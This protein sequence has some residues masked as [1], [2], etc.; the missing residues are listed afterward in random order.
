VSQ[1][2]TPD[3]ARAHPTRTLWILALGAMAYA[4]AQ[5]MIV[6]ALPEIQDATGSS[7]ETVTWMLTAFLL[8]SSVAIPLLGRLGDIIG[9]E[10]VLLVS[11]VTFGAGSLICAVG[12]SSIAVMIGGRLVQGIGGA[13]FPLCF[14]II[15]DEFPPERVAASIGAIS[16]TFGVG[17]GLGLVLAGVFVDHLSVAW[18]FWFSLAVTA[19]SVWA[20]WRYVP[21]SPVRV[22]ARI[23]WAGGALLSVA[24]AAALLGVSQGNA[25]GWGSAGVLGLL[26]AGAAVLAL[27]VAY[28]LRVSEPMVDMRLMAARAVWSPNVAAFAV[29][30]AMFGSYILIPELVQTD[31]SNGYGFGLS[32][33]TAGLVMLPSALVMLRSGVLAGR[34]SDRYGSRLPL[35]LGSAFAAL[36][37]GMLAFAHGSAWLVAI[38]GVPLGIGIGMAMAAMATLVVSVVPQEVTGIAMGVNTLMRNVGGAVGG[39]LAATLLAAHSLQNDVPAESGYTNAFALSLV[40]SIVALGACALVPKPAVADWRR[41]AATGSG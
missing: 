8:S 21:E 24:L 37:F 32:V 39:Q 13:V 4:L 26:A 5:T 18:I 16:T 10:K 33:T 36:A 29:G 1:D 23:D 27:F 34:L 22:Q 15:R 12:T 38:A 17:G 9:K 20:T 28:E 31:E 11:L 41:V 14:G 6:P 3:A 35:A 2:L 25:W 30:F 7:Q 40:A 19:T